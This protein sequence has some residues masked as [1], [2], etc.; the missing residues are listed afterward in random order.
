MKPIRIVSALLATAA[1]TATA[2]PALAASKKKDPSTEVPKLTVSAP[3][4]AIPGGAQGVLEVT[5]SA[6]G[7]LTL[8]ISLNGEEITLFDFFEI[9]S[10]DNELMFPAVDEAGEPLAPGAYTMTASMTTQYGTP[11]GD[12][13][14]TMTIGLPL[15][16][17]S[18]TPETDAPTTDSKK[19]E[20][21]KAEKPAEQ[22][23]A[24]SETPAAKPAEQA[25][26][27]TE[28]P[29]EKLE[30]KTASNT[31]VGDEGYEIGVGV[32]DVAA[33]DDAGYWGLDAAASDEAIWAALMRPMVGADVG[34]TESVYIYN[35][36]KD[37]RK[38]LGSISGISQGVNVIAEREDG[39]SL[40]EA[41]RNEDGAFVR[42]YI[43]SN[44]L[45]TVEPNAVYGLVIDKKAQTLVVY[46]DGQR[47]GSCPV[48]TG[49]PTSKYLHRETPAGE[50]ITVTRR[51]TTEYYGKGF[52][53][54]TIRVNGGYYIAE[55]PTTKKN[56]KDFSMLA[57]E[58]GAKATRGMICLPHDASADG[59]INAEWIW[60][61]TDENKKV[62]VLIL[63]D[64][65]RTDV[66][67]GK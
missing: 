32:S 53:K 14:G 60:N 54:Y 31:V 48:S 29:A 12:V 46:K 13:T 43:R 3:E 45:R 16:Q 65:A 4:T 19:D 7:F 41:F 55:I 67:S 50:F 8:T 22:A 23:P 47:I 10:E 66:P 35:S 21:V 57:D 25:P 1:L 56:G 20:P 2:C 36:T 40:V 64:K 42:G 9:H 38:K 5:A 61:M 28:K 30:Y 52:S 6:P 15:A 27:K 51:G 63:D 18:D 33:Q 44:K 34:E 62:K 37:S 17:Q 58:L 49:L 59:G 39:W 26:A 11:S 24:K